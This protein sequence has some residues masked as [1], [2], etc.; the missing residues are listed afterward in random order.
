MSAEPQAPWVARWLK[1][2]SVSDRRIVIASAGV[3]ESHP[4]IEGLLQMAALDLMKIRED[5]LAEFD[6]IASRTNI[7]WDPADPDAGDEA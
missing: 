4:I 6:R 7:P 2:L 1:E 3:I 5:E